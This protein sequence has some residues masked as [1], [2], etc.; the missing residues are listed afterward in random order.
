MNWCVGAELTLGKA[1]SKFSGERGKDE[2]C[3]L[4][5]HHII[6]S[7]CSSHNQNIYSMKPLIHPDTDTKEM[8]LI[9][10]A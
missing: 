10:F 5:P 3:P 2:P 4:A 9:C 1:F 6:L 7:N 8:S